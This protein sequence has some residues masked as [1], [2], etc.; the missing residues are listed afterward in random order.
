MS[1]D[2]LWDGSGEPDPEILKLEDTLAA[3]RHRRPAPA[4]PEMPAVAAPVRA[5][6]FDMRLWP[7]LAGVAAGLLLIS[8]LGRIAPPFPG[9]NAAN[10]GWGGSALPGVAHGGAGAAN[11]KRTSGKTPPTSHP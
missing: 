6:W 4:L 11:G 5:R 8:A 10:P 9:K 1:S 3:L 7:A 2:Y